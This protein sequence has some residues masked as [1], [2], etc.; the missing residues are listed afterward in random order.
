MPTGANATRGEP[1]RIDSRVLD[2]LDAAPVDD[3][4]VA[5]TFPDDDKAVQPE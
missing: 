5:I 3:G 4:D 1:V 2:E